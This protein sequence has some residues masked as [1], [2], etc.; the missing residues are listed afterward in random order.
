MQRLSEKENAERMKMYESGMTDKDM[1]KVLA[2]SVHSI[3]TWRRKRNF[4]PNYK[5]VH[6]KQ[7]SKHSTYLSEE[8]HYKR[9]EL[10]NKGMT[11]EE[12]AKECNVCKQA[13][14]AWRKVNGLSKN[15]K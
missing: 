1:A 7:N 6:G 5:V 8:K 4:S 10:Y 3:Y 13:I 12:I 14:Y 2:I 15:V 9:L 11:D